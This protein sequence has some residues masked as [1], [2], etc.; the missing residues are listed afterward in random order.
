M[1]VTFTKAFWGR[2]PLDMEST[3]G[4]IEWEVTYG[5][6]GVVVRVG[7]WAGGS[8]FLTAGNRFV[9]NFCTR[10]RNWRNFVNI[11]VP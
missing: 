4:C 3:Y 1:R 7:G 5:R 2:R 10:P 9:A 6:Q 8:Q 11:R